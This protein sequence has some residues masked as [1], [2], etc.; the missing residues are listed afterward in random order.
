MV[1]FALVDLDRGGQSQLIACSGTL[2]QGSLRV[3]RNGI[4]IQEQASVPL[5]CDI[6]SRTPSY[7]PPPPSPPPPLPPAILSLS[8][9]CCVLQ[10]SY[11]AHVHK[12]VSSL[13]HSLFILCVIHLFFL[14][15]NPTKKNTTNHC[16]VGVLG[17]WSLKASSAASHDA[18][19][20]HTV[21]STSVVLGFD[22]DELG[23]VEWPVTN[24]PL[25][26]V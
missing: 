22:G 6:L 15:F 12:I 23:E 21:G 25:A 16:Q 10:N 18:F 9:I 13:M 19:L 2:D 5:V 3:I 4:G 1:D 14:E 26:A 24:A 7:P 8:F 20:V 11:G 17:V